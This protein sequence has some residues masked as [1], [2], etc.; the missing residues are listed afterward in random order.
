MD[1]VID[2]NENGVIINNGF[3]SNGN[4]IPYLNWVTYDIIPGNK[5]N[6][7]SVDITEKVKDVNGDEMRA[8]VAGV[9]NYNTAERN[10]IRK[11]K[12]GSVVIYDYRLTSNDYNKT[13]Q[14]THNLRFGR[15]FDS[16]GKEGDTIFDENIYDGVTPYMSGLKNVAIANLD[17]RNFNASD[18]RDYTEL[19]LI[20]CD[21]FGANLYKINNQET[22]NGYVYFFWA[23]D[24]T[25]S[26]PS[27]F[28][29]FDNPNYDK[30]IA[31]LGTDYLPGRFKPFSSNYYNRVNNGNA[32]YRT[33]FAPIKAPIIP[34]DVKV[35]DDSRWLILNGYSGNI[36]YYYQNPYD[37][38]V[39]EVEG[40]YQGEAFEIT[41]DNNNIPKLT[42]SSNQFD[43]FAIDNYVN[44]TDYTDEELA[45]WNRCLDEMD[46]RVY[47]PQTSPI[48]YENNV[49]G[50]AKYQNRTLKSPKSL[51]R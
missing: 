37:G 32:L 3:T 23:F 1:L 34:M 35:L 6:F 38:I 20:L 9:A 18:V 46:F 5:N 44:V 43:S 33:T 7:V 21:E 27:R 40:N 8:V 17:G 26:V 2:T 28:F 47:S 14:A 39:Y 13:N 30:L 24:I 50:G 16:I 29:G 48:G 31:G 51:D 42:W 10:G 12:G 19:E 49:I 15:M 4:V 36:K 25:R 22:R 41:F 45:N 11:A